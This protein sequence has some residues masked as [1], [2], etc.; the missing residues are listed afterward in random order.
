[1]SSQI[2]TIAT[3][4][5]LSWNAR[6]VLDG[7]SG[8]VVFHTVGGTFSDGN[9]QKTVS[10]SNGTYDLA[11]T[12]MPP[13][14]VGTAQTVSVYYE[15]DNDWHLSQEASRILV[16][17]QSREIDYRIQ[18][19]GFGVLPQSASLSSAYNG[20][21]I[22]GEV[23]VPTGDNFRT[24]YAANK[25]LRVDRI[26]SGIFNSAKSPFIAHDRENG[27]VYFINAAST[28]EQLTIG[29][30]LSDTDSQILQ[31]FE[32]VVS[33]AREFVVFYG[34]GLVEVYDRG[35]NFLRQA[36]TGITDA[37][38]VVFR[39]KDVGTNTVDSFVLL[40]T[41]GQAVYL[42][43]SFAEQSRL[44]D[45][46]YTDASDSYDVLC[47]RSG[48]LVGVNTSN[49][50]PGFAFYQFV[51]SSLLA[52]GVNTATGSICQ[53]NIR[54][55]AL[56]APS[57]NLVQDNRVVYNAV[58]DWSPSGTGITGGL[59]TAGN[60]DLF[61]FVDDTPVQSAD[62]GFSYL[63]V[64]GES[65]DTDSSSR[66]FY[67]V[68][69]PTEALA[70]LNMRDYTATI[71]QYDQAGGT[72]V[73][74][75]LTVHTGDPDLPL[76]IRFPDGVTWTATVNNKQVK[77][78]QDGDFVK[79]TASHPT[80]TRHSFAFTIGRSTGLFEQQPDTM[81]DAFDF[82]D[83]SGID[84]GE[85]YQT[86]EIT[87]T[88][89]N[90]KV[91]VSVTVNGQP[92]TDNVQIYI[93]G[94][95]AT[96]PFMIANGG[97]LRLEVL[98]EGDSSRVDVAVGSGRADFGIYTVAEPILNTIR[99]WAYQ[100][101]G[102]EVVSDSITNP[103][104]QRVVLTLT[105]DTTALFDNGTKTVTLRQD[106]STRIKFTPEE[107]K[108]YHVVFNTEQHWYDWQVWADDQ[109]LDPQP[110][111]QRAERYVLGDSG[112]IH[113]NAIPPN[114]FTHI[115]VPAGILLQVNGEYVNLPLDV[116][117]VYNAQT[118]IR[119][120]ECSTTV[121]RMEG[122][123]SHDQPHT[124]LLGDAKLEWLYDFTADPTYSAIQNVVVAQMPSVYQTVELVA[125]VTASQSYVAQSTSRPAVYEPVYV[126]QTG[127]V[128]DT[129]VDQ[130]FIPHTG[131]TVDQS[132]SQNFASVNNVLATDYDT[133]F[134]AHVPDDI[135]V[136]QPAEFV[137][138]ID[139]VS[140][141]MPLP[142]VRLVP[143]SSVSKGSLPTILYR[144]NKIAAQIDSTS[145]A[146]KVSSPVTARIDSASRIRWVKGSVAIGQSNDR[147]QRAV[148]SSN[149][150]D[151]A[152]VNV[153]SPTAKIDLSPSR[154]RLVADIIHREDASVAHWQA[155]PALYHH[156]IWVPRWTHIPRVTFHYEM[157]VGIVY[158]PKS[159]PIGMKARVTG[160]I[161]TYH[162]DMAVR[163]VFD[164]LHLLG[165]GKFVR[166]HST[167]GAAI[168]SASAMY[169]VR[170]NVVAV[171]AGR[172][173]YVVAAAVN[174]VATAVARQ[175]Q[176]F[177]SN[178]QAP[179]EANRVR[180]TVVAVTRPQPKRVV[181]KT[182]SI[183]QA[184]L[185]VPDTPI[186][187]GEQ[188]P[189]KQGYFATELDALQNAVQVWGHDAGAVYAIKQ[190]NGYWTWAIVV[191]CENVC[192]SY[193]CDTR[194]YLSGG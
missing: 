95:A 66:R 104:P 28:I 81:P 35:M 161:R 170:P 123:P 86:E 74:F 19:Q 12:G 75:S 10:L 107:N 128:V 16:L 72:N 69:R 150:I 84:E 49:Q 93:D 149:W 147:L 38:R 172:G 183:P 173:S 192:G 15:W 40:T 190:P 77:Y 94:V 121:L 145:R 78:V 88:G 193:G 6:V 186:D 82:A 27:V 166:V 154:P 182:I 47:T 54:D 174:P 155:A 25:V 180:N 87:I 31:V 151:G 41:F 67:A 80:I 9:T 4:T 187:Y 8:D 26:P 63:G 112:D 51:P 89:I 136:A 134:V 58:A 30:T 3:N 32:R 103:G 156:K 164:V 140:A 116:R 132:W 120:L 146:R 188:D 185:E 191:T 162:H 181:V 133:R 76:E 55:N 115:R 44:T 29:A 56:Y 167:T 106:E 144:T 83:V 46:F 18:Q 163:H 168:A 36:D 23:K 64:Y 53:F 96:E 178:A 135:A 100:A 129:S 108:Q 71:P 101:T 7:V 22:I 169:R 175:T 138:G 143:W 109:W 179:A 118:E 184:V 124:I 90:T 33:G 114:F 125:H 113:F 102:V 17:P 50:P 189:V 73:E 148:Q 60:N 34:S 117:G 97:R 92:A 68:A 5:A 70:H 130:R 141:T 85:V 39:R 43:N 137:S 65:Y 131:V 177:S 48:Q 99:N 153:V 98:H 158:K 194:G 52:V 160:K 20:L 61:R 139:Y 11:L 159:Y 105:N 62:P 79:F 45:R 176:Q 111:D 119:N 152:G 171:D 57:R 24:A 122:L 42:N 37:K 91:P 14:D 110:A 1:M 59:D 142:S 127:S 21:A 13:Q 2:K 126:T 157:H 165:S